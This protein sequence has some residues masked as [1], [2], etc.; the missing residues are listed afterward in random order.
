MK[1]LS[2]LQALICLL[3]SLSCSVQEP[4]TINTESGSKTRIYATLESY[5][6]PDTRLYV[7]DKIQLHWDANDQISVFNKN[8]LNQQYYFTGNTGEKS[9]YFEKVSDPFGTGTDL[10]FVCAVYPYQSQSFTKI[11]NSGVMTLTLPAEQTY[12]KGSFGPGANTMISCS[13]SFDLL[14][15]K[16]VGGYL[17]LKFYGKG[18]SV[19]SIKLEG[20]GG[21]L[22][23]GKAT[24]APVVGEVP[25]IKMDP[26]AEKSGDNSITLICEKP[27][28][29]SAA[30][31]NATLF[32][33]VVPPTDFA[34]GFTLTVTNPDGKTFVKKT[35][36]SLSIVRNTL[37]R[38]APIEVAF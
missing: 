22:L 24:W 25:T 35:D 33:I 6:E 5:N 12:R 18:V 37:L 3:V 2:F 34:K 1:K 13:D 32:W 26:N 7:D 8:A 10:T 11:S 30:K 20:N 4:D 31:E 14:Q 38:I 23:S 17:V 19:S 36:K 15:F 21:E 28:E 9:G 29:L 27:V 16:N